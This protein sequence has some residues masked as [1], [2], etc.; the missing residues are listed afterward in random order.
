G[1]CRGEEEGPRRGDAEGRGPHRRG[2]DR[3][4]ES[5]EADREGAR[6]HPRLRAAPRQRHG[7]RVPSPR[8]RRSEAPRQEGSMSAIGEDVLGL[9]VTELSSR[10]RARSLSPVELTEAYLARI[11]R[12]AP[13]LNAFATPTPDLAR[14]QA[15]A[16]EAEIAGGHYRGPL[17]GIPY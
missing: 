17:H 12:Y 14:A 10:I 11:E 3:D 6:D 4:S 1:P 13:R 5:E 8:A 16:A 2:R 9:T 15:R 7:I